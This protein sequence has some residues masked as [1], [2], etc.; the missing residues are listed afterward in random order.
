MI[1]EAT[2]HTNNILFNGFNEPKY[3]IAAGIVLGGGVALDIVKN[4]REE[5]LAELASPLAD[6][7]QAEQAEIN[8]RHSRFVEKASYY[9]AVAL[10]SLAFV[11]LASPFKTNPREKGATTL[12]MNVN[13]TADSQDMTANNGLPV[14]RIQASITGSL[15]AASQSSSPTAFIV[16]ANGANLVDSTPATNKNLVRTNNRIDNYLNSD[17]RN[18]DKLAEG[19]SDALTAEGNQPND[20]IIEASYLSQDNLTS[21]EADKRDLRSKYPNDK[22]YAVVEGNSNNSQAI[23]AVNLGSPV[24]L[25]SFQ[26]VLGQANVLSATSTQKIK[27]DILSIEN[28]SHIIDGKE[29]IDYIDFNLGTALMALLATGAM[30]RRLSGMF[31]LRKFQGKEV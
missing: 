3:L 18:G 7:E 17:F 19:V 10:A 21:L 5:Q 22:I 31:R 14:S 16:S 27:N 23:G 6:P 15:E 12:V 29:P 13:N 30:K 20:I 9:G 24:D 4:K 11:Q 26:Q 2:L 25:S 8:N 28:R 1:E